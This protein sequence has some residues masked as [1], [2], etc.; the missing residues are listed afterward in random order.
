M[1][2]ESNAHTKSYTMQTSAC[3]FT[4]VTFVKGRTACGE[5]DE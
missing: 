1:W 5:T 3:S 2:D 4:K